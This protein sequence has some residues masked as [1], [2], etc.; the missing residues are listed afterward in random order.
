MRVGVS[1]ASEAALVLVAVDAGGIAVGDSTLTAVVLCAGGIAEPVHEQTDGGEEQRGFVG[2]NFAGAV[3]DS[4]PHPTALVASSGRQFFRPAAGS[5]SD[6]DAG[7]RAGGERDFGAGEQ[8]EFLGGGVFDGYG[9]GRNMQGANAEGGEG[10]GHG[11]FG[12]VVDWYPSQ[13]SRKRKGYGEPVQT[14]IFPN[15]TC[16]SRKFHRRA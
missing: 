2:G 9:G 4:E 6:V 11:Y 5:E 3:G 1:A 12:T 10:R 14:K 15:R 13:A 16:N 8:G 7:A